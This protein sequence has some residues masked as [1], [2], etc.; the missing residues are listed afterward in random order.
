M[1]KSTPD[2]TFFKSTNWG[3]LKTNRRKI[4]FHKRLW[5]IYSKKRKDLLKINEHIK[6]AEEKITLQKKNKKK[7][8]EIK[9]QNKDYNQ[10]SN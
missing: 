6:N 2:W 10:N 3:I 1:F 5:K 7:K 4:Y 9:V 8:S